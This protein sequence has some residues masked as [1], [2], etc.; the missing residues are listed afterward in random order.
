MTDKEFLNWIIDR[1]IH[2]YGES[3]YVDFIHKL[4]NIA[5]TIPSDQYTPNIIGK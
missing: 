5:K 4:R 2:V 1:L 3:P